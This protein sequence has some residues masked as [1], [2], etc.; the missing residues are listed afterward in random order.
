MDGR[1]IMETFISIKDEQV[2]L[3]SLINNPNHASNVKTA[4]KLIS[5]FGYRDIPEGS[6]DVRRM[7]LYLLQIPEMRSRYILPYLTEPQLYTVGSCVAFINYFGDYDF[8]KE[9]KLNN[10][11][12]NMVRRVI[13]YFSE[14]RSTNIII[15]KRLFFTEAG[16]AKLDEILLKD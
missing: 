2:C 11:Y 9:F 4:I 1:F 6:A 7:F 15:P 5:Q 14:P 16:I 8:F 12:E 3:A 10:Y 13:N